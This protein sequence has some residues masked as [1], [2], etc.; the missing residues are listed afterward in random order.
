MSM[1]WSRGLVR[2][3]CSTAYSSPVWFDWCVYGT[4]TLVFLGSLSP[5]QIPLPARAV[6][7]PLSVHDPSVRGALSLSV[8]QCYISD[9]FVLICYMTM[10]PLRSVTPI[11]NDGLLRWHTY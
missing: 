5:Y 4:L 1:A 6:A 2:S 10:P 11:A 3:A 9:R 8:I 7:L